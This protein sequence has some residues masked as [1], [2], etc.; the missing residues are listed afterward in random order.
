MESATLPLNMTVPCR[1][2]FPLAGLRCGEML[3]LERTEVDLAKRQLCVQQ[4]AW[5]G[6][7]TVPKG[8][9]NASCHSRFDWRRPF[10]RIRT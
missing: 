1:L 8:G 3:A 6:H 10:E 5:E 7:I 4:S 9:D 2:S